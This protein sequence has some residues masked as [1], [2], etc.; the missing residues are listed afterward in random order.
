MLSNTDVAAIQTKVDR[1]ASAAAVRDQDMHRVRLVRRGCIDQLYPEHF[2]DEI[3]KSV[4]GNIIDVAA[5]DTAEMI[6]PLPGLACA[7]GNMVTAADSARASKKNKIGSYYWEKSNLARQNIDFADA[8]LSYGFGVYI[9]EPDFEHKCP[10]IR[11]ESSFGA[12]YYQNLWKETVWYAK[13]RYIDVATLCAQY[14]QYSASIK[15]DGKK[16]RDGGQQVRI[17]SYRDA[18]RMLVYLPDCS[19]LVLSDVANPMSRVGV[20]IAERPDQEELPR[21]QFDDVVWPALAKARMAQ[22]MLKAADLAV[23]APIAIPEDVTELTYGPDAVLRSANPQQIQRVRLDIPDDVFVLSGELDRAAKEGSRYPDARTGGVQGSIITGRGVQELM[24]TM[25]TQVRTWQTILAQALQEVT[26]LCFEMDV[27]LWPDTPKTIQGVLSGKPFEL[28]YTPSRDIGTTFGCKVVYGFAAGLSP[29]QAIVMLLQLRADNAISLDTF[30]RQLPFD[31]D[32]EEEQRSV[33]VALLADA[34]KQGL[35]GLGQA[36]GPMVMQ[37][38]D[39]LPVLRAMA[40]V[41]ELRQKG[42]PV[43]EALLEAFKP[44]EAPE[45][46]PEPVPGVPGAPVDPNAAPSEGEL[47]PGVRENGYMEGTPYGQMGQAPGGMPPVQ[48]LMASMRGSGQPRVEA[49]VMR[50]RGLNS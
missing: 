41:I 9:V 1:A 7:S 22:Y 32:P 11:W 48:A 17:V 3:P 14:P 20:V 43:H 28:T 18:T 13:V 31:L 2:A 46:T 38:Q 23:N 29:S 5:R 39:P 49:T 47:P 27:A 33:D 40:T 21:G 24:G 36:F 8:G 50:K 15:Y 25:D 42:K 37:G 10:R 34:A 44:P 12:Y 4:V 6:A 19:N 35:M 16:E 30:R 26:S 45:P